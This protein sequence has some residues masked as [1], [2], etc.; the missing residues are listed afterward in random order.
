MANNLPLG[1]FEGYGIEIEYMIVNRD[2]LNIKSIADKLL[3]KNSEI[4]AKE[5][6]YSNELATHN[7]GWNNTIHVTRT[8]KGPT[9]W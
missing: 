9:L 8:T 3:N 5:L 4:K 2:S 6:C 1:L 7:C